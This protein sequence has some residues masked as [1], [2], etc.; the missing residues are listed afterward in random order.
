MSFERIFVCF[1]AFKIQKISVFGR[2]VGY[3]PPCSQI[4][5]NK[6]EIIQGGGEITYGT[7][8]MSIQNFL[9]NSKIVLIKPCGEAKHTKTLTLLCL[10]IKKSPKIIKIHDS[11][12]PGCQDT[13]LPHCQM[14]ICE[15][16]RHLVAWHHGSKM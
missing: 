7:E 1:G 12:L 9:R 4:C 8:V 15:V 16:P 11:R 2:K 6:G 13:S 3:F 10:Y 5:Q 14:S